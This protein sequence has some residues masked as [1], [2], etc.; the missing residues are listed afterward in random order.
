MM[1]T[2]KGLGVS[3][4]IAI[5]KAVLKESRPMTIPERRI[6]KECVS[7]EVERLEAAIEKVVSDI[8]RLINEFSFSNVEKEILHSHKL[9][10]QDPELKKN[11]IRILEDELVGLENAVYQH[12]AYA[13]ELFENMDNEYYAERVSDYREI[14]NRLLGFMMGYEEDL[15]SNLTRDSILILEEIPVSLLTKVA[16]QGI[17]GIVS[18]IGS[19]TSHSSIVARALGIPAVVG[20]EG[21]R[22]AVPQDEE[23][24]IDGYS[25]EV[26]VSPTKQKTE[27]YKHMIEQQQHR[28]DEL[29]KL[30]DL[31]AKTKDGVRINLRCNIE[32]PDE[33]A[34]VKRINADG[35]GLFRT[36]FIYIG[37][38]EL[39]DEN[40]QFEAYKHI[41]EEM[42]PKPVVIRTVDIGGDKLHSLINLR[43]EENPNLGCR[44]IRLSLRHQE[45]FHA[46]LK[47]ILRASHYGNVRVMFPMVSSLD[48]LLR[49]KQ[50]VNE[51]MNELRKNGI[52]FDDDIKLGV[53]IEVPSAAMI[54]DTLAQHCDFFS[55]GTNDLIQYTLAVDRNSENVT[56]YYNP[57]HPAMMHLITLIVQNARKYNLPVSVCGEMASDR[58]FIPIL[59]GLGITELSTN[60]GSLLTIKEFIGKIDSSVLV[61]LVLDI[62]DQITSKKVQK[63]ICQ[64]RDKYG[65]KI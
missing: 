41:A 39:P 58:D 33:L 27:I 11:V 12:F 24:V 40:Q 54:S 43:H 61:E 36:E 44:G 28:S 55:I 62:L 63:T 35:I 59:L 60:P 17:A 14:A 42:N 5:G 29:M 34:H 8:D 56:D 18:E 23:I 46:Q 7:K 57:Y 3:H 50:H 16:K 26:V 51:C 48:E 25:G 6:E 38:S 22:K 37:D 65:I 49:A 21:I 9:I 52:P 4:G 1:Q 2:L 31:P 47:A 13:I 10:L 19:R 30:V 15:M 53:M 64:W 45:M 32:L 20:V